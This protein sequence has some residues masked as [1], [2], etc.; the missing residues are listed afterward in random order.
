MRKVSKAKSP[1][2][3]KIQKNEQKKG[4]LIEQVILYASHLDNGRISYIW[5][6]IPIKNPYYLATNI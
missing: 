3:K 5:F 2:V 4:T 6:K 1:N